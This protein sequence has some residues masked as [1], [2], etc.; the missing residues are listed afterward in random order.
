[1]I[2]II[3]PVYN[4]SDYLEACFESLSAQT[5]KD[6]EIVAIDDGST[7]DSLSICTKWAQKDQRIKVIHQG[8]K[9]SAAARN[10][11]I[12]EA[13]GEYLMFVDSDDFVS[14]DYVKLL[15]EETVKNNT[16]ISFCNYRYELC[17]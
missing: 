6:I 11:G 2:S 15:N 13:S 1:M 7:D 8:N 14:P 3:V 17:I 16:D 12:D 10:R 9:G 4:T 5:F